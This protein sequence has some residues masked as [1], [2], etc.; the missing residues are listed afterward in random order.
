MITC[1]GKQ[2]HNNLVDLILCSPGQNPLVQKE[3]LYI[4]MLSLPQVVRKTEVITK[5]IQELLISAQE[6]RQDSFVPCADQIHSAVLDMDSIFPKVHRHSR[7]R[8]P[9]E[10]NPPLPSLPKNIYS[11]RVTIIS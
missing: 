9:Y 4:N 7:E 8:K 5:R 11:S 1:Y 10:G 6:G 3:L 2:Y